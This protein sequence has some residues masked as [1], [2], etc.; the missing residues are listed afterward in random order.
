MPK[1]AK[2]KLRRTIWKKT[3]GVCAHCGRTPSTTN[4]TIDH[5]I[6][7]ILGGGYDK[8]NLMPL[9]KEC[10]KAKMGKLIDPKEY[11]KFAPQ[12]A[13]DDCLSYKMSFYNFDAKNDQDWE[14]I[15]RNNLNR[16]EEDDYEFIE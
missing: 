5:F 6:P 12:E 7:R 10:N 9:C 4:Q 13:I 3:R 8:R 1:R 14:M 11:Y 15:Q 2:V 16:E